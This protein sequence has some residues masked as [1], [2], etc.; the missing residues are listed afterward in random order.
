[1]SLRTVC[2][3]NVQWGVERKIEFGHGYDKASHP[4]KMHFI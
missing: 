3:M 2:K 1:M 4:K